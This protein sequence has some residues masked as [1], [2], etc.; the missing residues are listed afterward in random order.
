[1]NDPRDDLRTEAALEREIDA[2]LRVQPSADFLAGVRMRIADEPAPRAGWVWSAWTPH[3]ALAAGAAA[4]L[5]ALSV[6]TLLSRRPASLAGEARLASRSLLIV[7]VDTRGGP[8][9]ARGIVVPSLV[10]LDLSSFETRRIASRWTANRGAPVPPVLVST[11]ESKA[12]RNLFARAREGR[13]ALPTADAIESDLMDLP[14]ISAI[15]IQPITIE[16]LA[17]AGREEGARQ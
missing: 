2:A 6:G 15:A 11:A 13:L 17:P 14:P 12:L 5:L 10:G 1:M 3:A 8:G 9:D 7:P 16:L 4:A